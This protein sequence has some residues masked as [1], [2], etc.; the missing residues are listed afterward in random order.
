MAKTNRVC[1]CCGHE[2]YFCPS[3]PNDRKDP[4]IYTMFDSEQCKDIF[5]TLVKESTKKIT[6]SECK[7]ALIRLG[8][9]KV[10]INKSSVKN[11]IDRVMSYASN[12]VETETETII[13]TVETETME[14]EITETPLVTDEDVNIDV[15][16]TEENEVVE[17]VRPKKNNYK[18]NYR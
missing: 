4:Q 8:A 15:L 17:V 11:H 16:K 14:T 2:Y 10:E 3:C 6:T 1:Y 13:E 12:T 7:E 9:E 18:K 5:N